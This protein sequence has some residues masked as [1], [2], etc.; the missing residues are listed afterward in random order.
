MTERD[1]GRYGEPSGTG[2]VRNYHTRFGDCGGGRDG[3]ADGEVD[4]E[5]P[6]QQSGDDA[7]WS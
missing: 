3:A 4:D 1:S 6:P 5:L 2:G 7:I